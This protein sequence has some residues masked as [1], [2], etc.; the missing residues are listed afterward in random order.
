[1]LAKPRVMDIVFDIVT[2]SYVGHFF[3]FFGRISTIVALLLLHT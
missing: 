1:M 3:F 2:R